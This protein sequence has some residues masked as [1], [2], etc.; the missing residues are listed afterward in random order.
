MGLADMKTKLTFEEFCI[1][2]GLA[3]LAKDTDKQMIAIV[4]AVAKITG[5]V[6]DEN[7]YGHAADLVYS[8]DGANP[9]ESI[10]CMLSNL[11]IVYE[12]EVRD[13]EEAE[14][15]ADVSDA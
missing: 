8:P 10:K 13:G 12:K 9:T 6:L 5:E 2:V 1:L 7:D 3:Y 15:D 11:G 4:R 14:A